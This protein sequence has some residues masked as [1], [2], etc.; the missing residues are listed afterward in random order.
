M[1]WN[2]RQHR[3]QDLERELRAHLELEA[4]E[5]RAAGSP[6]E[7]AHYAAQRTLGNRTAIQEE[8]REVWGWTAIEQIAQDTRYALRGMRKS[9]GFAFIAVLSLGLGIGA[10]TAI[11]TGSYMPCCS[12]RCRS[13]S[14]SGWCKDWNRNPRKDGSEMV[15]NPLNFLDWRERTHSFEETAAV[16]GQPANLTGFGDPVALNEGEVS[17]Q[18]FSNPGV[19]PHW[20]APSVPRKDGRGQDHVVILSFGLWQARFGGDPG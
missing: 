1:H 19:F 7:H 10:N 2:R 4:E 9:P 6:A 5:Q 16:S 3:E 13:R 17:P 8:V 15:P 11:F 20:A 12:S 18:Y 14:R